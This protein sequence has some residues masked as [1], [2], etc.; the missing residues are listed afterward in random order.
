MTLG[1]ASVT[2][3]TRPR[4]LDLRPTAGRQS[5][6]V[7]IRRWT[8]PGTRGSASGCA[9][10]A[11]VGNSSCNSATAAERPTTIWPTTS[12]AGATSNWLGLPRI[13]S[14][15]ARCG[16]SPSTTTVCRARRP[17]R[18]ASGDV[19]ALR[20]LDEQVLVDSFVEIGGQRWQWKGELRPGQHV[21]FWPDGAH[22]PLR[23]AAQTAGTIVREG[24]RDDFARR[25]AHDPLWLPRRAAAARPRTCHASAGRAARNL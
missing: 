8:S 14:T 17:S 15:T 20:T 9:A 2:R 11:A 25:P 21:V 18:A 12:S 6:K 7:S 23:T 16:R 13:R 10:T 24:R 5:A 4:A 3:F 1:K 19:K 22:C